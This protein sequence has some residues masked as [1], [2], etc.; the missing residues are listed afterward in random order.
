[1]NNQG[2]GVP[3][4]VHPGFLFQPLIACCRSPMFFTKGRRAA[5]LHPHRSATV[6]ERCPK[7]RLPATPQ[8]R[9]EVIL[10]EYRR[11]EIIAAVEATLVIEGMKPGGFVDNNHPT[12]PPKSTGAY[13]SDE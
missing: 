6:P 9:K 7:L 10:M 3:G 4:A 8:T 1:M 2:L 13:L 11:P 12:L 5:L